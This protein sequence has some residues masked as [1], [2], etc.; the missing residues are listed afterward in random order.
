MLPWLIFIAP[1]QSIFIPT[2]GEQYKINIP[3]DSLIEKELKNF[4][5]ECSKNRYLETKLTVILSSTNYVVYNVV[6]WYLQNEQY[7]HLLIGNCSNET[8]ISFTSEEQSELLILPNIIV[9]VKVELLIDFLEEIKSCPLWSPNSN[10]FFIIPN[11]VNNKL[12]IE[13][14]LEIIWLKKILNFVVV[15]VDT[16]INVF[17]YNGFKE[18]KVIRYR[19]FSEDLFPNK[20]LDING[21][22]LK[23]GMFLDVPRNIKNSRGQWHGPDYH[24]L[25]TVIFMMNATLEIVEVPPEQHYFALFD[26]VANETID[27]S[28]I[29][30]YQID[31]AHEVDFSYPRKLENMVVLV[32]KATLIPRR[33][34]LFLVLDYKI[35][36]ATLAFLIIIT[37]VLKKTTF[38]K[39]KNPTFGYWMLISWK[40][41]IGNG[42]TTNFQTRHVSVKIILTSWMLLS[43]IIGASFQCSFTST[44]T[45]PKYHKD[46][47][48]LEA[49]R[50]SRIR[51]L[52]ADYF[53]DYFLKTESHEL[54]KQLV[55][56]DPEVIVQIRNGWSAGKVAFIETYGRAVVLQKFYGYHIVKEPIATGYTVYF[57]QKGS[58]FNEEIHRCVLIDQE[59]GL[60]KRKNQIRRHLRKKFVKQI[61][62]DH[63][64]L[65]FHHLQGI[66]L[67]L[68]IF[69]PISIIVF[70]CEIFDN[71]SKKTRKFK[72]Y[73][74]V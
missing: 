7:E 35:S 22:V 20:L 51:I 43:I 5:T 1:I 53:R 3:K 54:Q 48:T 56:V 9:F 12:V 21:H 68:L 6:Q 71:G 46:I 62:T 11:L 34:Y 58:P 23:V 69:Y 74:G 2:F 26:Y 38:S 72:K 14:I 66:F 49:L 39:N 59:T 15:Y 19:N 28:F 57:F 44:L 50:A 36:L 61:T 33:N 8:G 32:P 73:T 29:P 64:Y 16:E 24:V 41:F 25:E 18:E 42:G 10:I 52:C 17:T 4:F 37:Y 13:E 27:F 47:N 60:S 55:F 70:V 67:V 63:S 30:Y 45:K 65:T 40:C 31:D